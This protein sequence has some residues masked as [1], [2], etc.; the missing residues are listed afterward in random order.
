MK[1]LRDFT[2][3]LA[4]FIIAALLG[5]CVIVGLI[6]I[7]C[8]EVFNEVVFFLFIYYSLPAALGGAIIFTLDG[9]TAKHS[10]NAPEYLLED[11]F[12]VPAIVACII[13]GPLT[14][15]S[16]IIYLIYVIISCTKRIL[17][18]ALYGGEPS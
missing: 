10:Y 6:T 12:A 2:I 3:Y 4:I 5:E 18:T 15:V 16:A 8:T 11:D 9:I 17:V 13:F 7:A 1:A 14:L